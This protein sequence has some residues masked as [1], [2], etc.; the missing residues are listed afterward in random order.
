MGAHLNS[1][2]LR[3]PR[4]AGFDQDGH[5]EPRHSTFTHSGRRLLRPIAAGLLRKAF[6]SAR[7]DR[8]ILNL[9]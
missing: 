8:N 6:A 4:P 9:D 3:P 1:E 7:R 5:S 2:S